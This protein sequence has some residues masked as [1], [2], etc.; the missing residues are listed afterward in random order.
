MAIVKI[1]SA[2]N[3]DANALEMIKIFANYNKQDITYSYTMGQTFP[4]VE[5]KILRVEVNGQELSKLMEKKEIPLC[6]VDNSYL[7]WHGKQAGG[8]LKLLREI[9]G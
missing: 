2:S 4:T 9:L 3:D 8:I 1:H 5:G 7:I 6:S